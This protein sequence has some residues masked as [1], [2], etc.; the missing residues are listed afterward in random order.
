MQIEFGSCA[1]LFGCV[2]RTATEV[3]QALRAKYS[4]TVV[5]QGST[6]LGFADLAI[7]DTVQ[8][9]FACKSFI[10]TYMAVLVCDSS[11]N[12]AS[13]KNVIPYDYEG[14][15]F[16]NFRLVKPKRLTFKVGNVVSIESSKN[17]LV[18]TAISSIVT[19]SLLMDYNAVTAK[20]NRPARRILR[21]TMCDI[22]RNKGS[23]DTLASFIQTLSIDGNAFVNRLRSNYFANL[24]LAINANVKGLSLPACMKKYGINDS[25]EISYFAKMLLEEN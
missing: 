10:N 15:I 19:D 8:T 24:R 22:I 11:P 5:L 25:Y 9:L 3:H 20:M 21:A 23:I 2:G 6:S 18:K 14:D 1:A 4:T 12:I 17:D 13:L 16:S 7:I